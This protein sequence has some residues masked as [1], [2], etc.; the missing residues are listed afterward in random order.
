MQID[1]GRKTNNNNNKSAFSSQANNSILYIV[2]ELKS[3]F[4]DN[5]TMYTPLAGT[6]AL[7]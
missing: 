6:G 4:G 3:A 7:N 2:C 1:R 5:Q